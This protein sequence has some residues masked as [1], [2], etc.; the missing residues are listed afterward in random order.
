[1]SDAKVGR[2]LILALIAFHWAVL[3]LIQGVKA[4]AQHYTCQYTYC[5]PL[6]V[7]ADQTETAPYTA[8]YQRVC[9]NPQSTEEAD[10]CQQWRMAEATEKMEGTAARQLR[11]TYFEI[12]GLLFTVFF[13]AWAAIAASKAARAANKSISVTRELGQKQIR[14]Y[15]GI[16]D[17]KVHDFRLGQ[18]VRLDLTMRN[19][20]RSPAYNVRPSIFAR[21]VVSSEHPEFDFASLERGQS[22]GD[23]G[24]DGKFGTG[25]LFGKPCSRSFIDRITSGQG[26]FVVVGRIEYRDVFDESHETH[27]RMRLLPESIEN[28]VGVLVPEEAGNRST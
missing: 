26:K 24:A 28:G 12:A 15:V 25:C 20:G 19:S 17:A 23:V 16:I 8:D 21:S 2:C 22:R 6:T 9:D 13:T 3:S 14:A 27:F 11:A 5:S 18:V 7:H 10:L 4:D 1:M